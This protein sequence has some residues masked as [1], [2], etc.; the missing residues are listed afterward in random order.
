[1]YSANWGM[2]ESFSEKAKIVEARKGEKN[3]Y[4]NSSC[5]RSAKTTNFGITGI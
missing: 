1:M 2:R 4:M 3:V 5:R